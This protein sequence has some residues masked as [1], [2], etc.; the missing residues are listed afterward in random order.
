MNMYALAA[1][2]GYDACL[3]RLLMKFIDEKKYIKNIVN[4]IYL[5]FVQKAEHVVK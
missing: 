5:W 2:I 4:L 1:V 3:Y